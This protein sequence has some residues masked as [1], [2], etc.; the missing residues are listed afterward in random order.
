MF[1]FFIFFCVLDIPR[2][3]LQLLKNSIYLITCLGIGCEISIASGVVVF[4]PKYL[5]TQFGTSTSVAN[6]FT[7]TKYLYKDSVVSKIHYIFAEI[8]LFTQI[9][10]R[11]MTIFQS[12]KLHI[13]S[14]FLWG[15][16]SPLS[17]HKYRG[18]I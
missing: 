4:L 8:L 3:I 10:C 5:E 17:L 15:K 6:L 9:E 18:K 2:S 11:K 14:K 13:F 1:L 16:N 7:G 12:Q